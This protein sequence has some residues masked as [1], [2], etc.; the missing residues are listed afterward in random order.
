VRIELVVE[1]PVEVSYSTLDRRFAMSWKRGGRTGQASRDLAATLP[2]RAMELSPGNSL[3]HRLSSSQARAHEGA[4]PIVR[5]RL[6][7][8]PSVIATMG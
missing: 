8:A 7:R 1:F 2:R 5:S 4:A 6:G 3:F